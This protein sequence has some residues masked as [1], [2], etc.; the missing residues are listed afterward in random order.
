[1]DLNQVNMMDSPKYKVRIY[2]EA[3]VIVQ[4]FQKEE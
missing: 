3:N 1:M 4:T 2:K